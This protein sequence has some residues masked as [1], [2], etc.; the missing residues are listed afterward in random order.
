MNSHD[1]VT[2][3]EVMSPTLYVVEGLASIREAIEIMAEHRVSSLVV[4]RRD[5]HDEY[6]LIVVND[7]AEQVIGPNRSPD[8]TS[9][10]EV[11][12]KPVLTLEGEMDIKYAIRLLA[13]FGISRALVLEHRDL[14]G[15]VTL[16]DLVL[17]YVSA[18]VRT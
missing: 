11:M 7:I 9:V 1:R 15:I 2:V 8:R 12:S 4:D 10:Y 5:E 14:V 18:T 16:R 3:R 6:G 13:R 17:R